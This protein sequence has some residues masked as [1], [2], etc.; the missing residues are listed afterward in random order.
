MVSQLLNIEQE[1]SRLQNMKKNYF[2]VNKI[3]RFFEDQS[4]NVFCKS[5]EESSYEETPSPDSSGVSVT[6]SD[7]H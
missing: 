5:Q 3:L 7:F 6:S 2:K 1:R 4:L